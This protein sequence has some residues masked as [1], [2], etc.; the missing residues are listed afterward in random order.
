M[1]CAT[2]L[3]GHSAGK[4]RAQM[5]AIGWIKWEAGTRVTGF[6][7]VLLK[8]L[9]FPLVLGF[10]QR[11]VLEGWQCEGAVSLTNAAFMPLGGIAIGIKP[12]PNSQ[13]KQRGS[14]YTRVSS[15]SCLTLK[16]EGLWLPK[17]KATELIIALAAKEDTVSWHSSIPQVGLVPTL[18]QS[19]IV[20]WR[21]QRFSRKWRTEPYGPYQMSRG[22]LQ[23]EL[24][25]AAVTW[26]I[27]FIYF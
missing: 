13:D 6:M 4:N 24:D 5:P 23:M 16:A 8:D 10:T 27:K 25:L 21:S 19:H 18:P 1:T 26:L 17:S 15:G 2:S 14:L 20:S 11:D 9:Y 22:T 3:P 7:P 12:S